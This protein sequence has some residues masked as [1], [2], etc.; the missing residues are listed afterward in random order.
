[1]LI[2]ISYNLF[3]ADFYFLNSINLGKIKVGTQ[4]EDEKIFK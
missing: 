2:S 1:M 3:I 4:I